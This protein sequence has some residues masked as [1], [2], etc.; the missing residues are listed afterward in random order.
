MAARFA[1]AARPPVPLVE[2][3]PDVLGEP[4]ADGDVMFKSGGGSADRSAKERTNG[5]GDSPG[6]PE[7]CSPLI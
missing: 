1:A 6:P 3:A 2:K 5:G 4:W 7:L